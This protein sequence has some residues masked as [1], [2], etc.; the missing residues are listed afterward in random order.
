MSDLPDAALIKRTLDGDE[1]AFAELV[2]RYQAPVAR[3]VY[4]TLGNSADTEDAV[5]EVFLRLYTSLARFDLSYPLGP[6]IFRIANNFCIDQL[7]RR[8]RLRYRLWTDL[9]EAEQQRAMCD[10]SRNGD[11]AGLLGQ[12]P[13]KYESVAAGLL[14]N[15]KPKYRVAFALREVESRSY[16]DIAAQL[17]ISQ[18]TARVRVSRARAE[19]RRK[20]EAYLRES[21]AGVR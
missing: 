12:S 2:R 18:L 16:P 10:L 17:G 11:F 6:W 4:R 3:V 19:I 1:A 13:E 9:S 5:Q 14:E 15:L 21:E 20:F 7:R 8:R